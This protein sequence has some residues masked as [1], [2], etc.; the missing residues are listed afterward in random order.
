MLKE[1]LIHSLIA[2]HCTSLH[3]MC[4][5]HPQVVGEHSSR[6]EKEHGQRMCCQR[7]LEG[8]Q[9]PTCCRHIACTGA[10]CNHGWDPGS[11]QATKSA[12]HT[13]ALCL[14]G[15]GS[16]SVATGLPLIPGSVYQTKAPKHITI[17]FKMPRSH[18]ERFQ[19]HAFLEEQGVT[20]R[21]YI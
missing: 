7:T 21:E 1:P 11:A 5:L 17:S 13:L 6:A 14:M 15:K 12:S 10:L 19:V 16:A 18:P 3:P 4:F 8:K 9:N 2:N 20:G